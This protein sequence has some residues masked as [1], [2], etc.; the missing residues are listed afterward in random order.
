[1]PKAKQPTKKEQ[2]LLDKISEL[3]TDLQR[4]RADFENY[5]KRSDADKETA[6]EIGK[7]TA[8]LKL[9]PIIDTIERATQH[10]PKE[11]TDNNWAQGI[12]GLSKQLEKNLEA[13]QLERIAATPGTSFDPELHE[14]VQF[15]DEA[16]GDTEVIAAE[17][18]PGYLYGKNVIRHSMVKVTR[19]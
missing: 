1:M 12:I 5:R 18:Q 10:V 15:D 13:L 6:K 7:S 3:T 8:I 14:A 2:E 17:L 11:L 9:L 4:L 16:E 19:Q